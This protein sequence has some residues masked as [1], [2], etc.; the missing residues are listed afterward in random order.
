MN[1]A[2]IRSIK[3][4]NF[5]TALVEVCGIKL[6]LYQNKISELPNDIVRVN[7]LK[8]VTLIVNDIDSNKIK[9]IEAKMPKVKIYLL[10]LL[11][12]AHFRNRWF[13][14]AGNCQFTNK[15]YLRQRELSSL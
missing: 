11:P 15:L 13:F 14:A 3:G 6:P 9:K 10:K 12:T 4:V 7:N 8:E 2:L 5:L 1:I